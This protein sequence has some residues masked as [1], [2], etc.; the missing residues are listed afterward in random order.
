MGDGIDVYSDQFQVHTG[1]YGC[2]L[3]FLLTSPTPPAPGSP[4]QASRVATVRM[5]LEHMKVMTYMLRQQLLE[6]ERRT[7]T[8]VQLPMEML[9]QL[10]IGRE[11]WDNLWR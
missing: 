9:N 10:R 3:N 11:D 1:P 4:V 5:S 7:G 2:T 8:T 6:Y